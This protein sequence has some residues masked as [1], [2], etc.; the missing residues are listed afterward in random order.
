MTQSER[1]DAECQSELP[2][3]LALVERMTAELRHAAERVVP[4]FLATM[5]ASYFRGTDFE[6]RL[7]HIKAVIAAEASGLSQE[8]ILRHEDG[9]RFTYLGDRNYPGQLAEL[10]ELLP[11]E[12]A[13]R[14]CTVHTSN[15]G[16]LVLDV[17]EL[18]DAPRFDPGDP[19]QSASA[20]EVL[21]HAAREE[22]D[23]DAPALE[24]HFARCAAD[25]LLSAPPQRICRHFRLFESLRGS[26]DCRVEIETLAASPLAQLVVAV[27]N[28]SPQE[29]LR[30][31]SRVFGRHEID[32][33]SA[34]LDRFDTPEGDNV[35]LL[36]FLVRWE[37]EP[38]GDGD[39]FEPLREDLM[40]LKWLDE[41]ALRLWRKLPTADLS[42]AEALQALC[43]LAHQVLTAL[44]PLAF[45]RKHVIECV[46]EHLPL[47]IR[48]AELFERRFDPE[49]PLADTAFTA[50]REEI[51][52]AIEESLDDE[53][54]REVFQTLLRAVLATRASNL[55]RRGRYAL[56]LELDPALLK[57][58]NREELPH[59]VLFV[60]GRDFDGF[61]L[62]FRPIARGGLRLVTPKGREQFFREAERLY[63]EAYGLAFAQQLKNKDIPEGGAKGVVLVAPLG[64]V[65][66]CAKAFASALLDMVIP[67]A[68]TRAGSSSKPA[69]MDRLYLGPDEN[70]TTELITWIVEHAASRGYPV[71]NSFMSSKPGAGINH[72]TYGVTSEGLSVFLEAALKACGIDPRARPFTL[73]LTGGPDGDVGGNTIRI[74][75]RDYAEHARIVGI[76]DGSGCAEDPQGLDHAELLRLV[77]AGL[78]VASF[79]RARLGPEGRVVALHEPNGTKLR[80]TLHNRVV[81]DAFVP[82]GGRP[83]TL[84]EGNWREFL[85][86]TNEPSAKLI[87]EGAN[88]FLTPEARRELS[89][90]GVLIV[91]DSS[92][93]KC[94]VITSSFEI[95]AS[96]LL[97]ED[98]FLSVKE[99]FVG[100]VIVRLRDLAR[101]EAEFLMREA[102][103]RPGIPLPELST[104]LSRVLIAASDAI[105]PCL[106]RI[107]REEPERLW[108]LMEE[109]LPPV[110][111][112]RAVGRLRTQLPRGYACDAIAKSLAGTIVYR[113]GL[114]YLEGMEP[115]AI[116]DL[117]LRYVE[118]ERETRALASRVL[119]SRLPERE[120][121]AA[122]LRSSATRVS[123]LR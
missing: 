79:E 15:D 49:A 66:L 111:R 28:C 24:E 54:E 95:L 13:L 112:E 87:V 75:H 94:G 2:D 17:F 121:I 44:N 47:A 6:T 1:S 70:V 8:L 29:M 58:A 32:I 119:A 41:A 16:R 90:R 120:R 20:R 123:P 57:A 88:L 55:H 9:S 35:C 40:R 39:P 113:E 52:R 108:S 98:E 10:L 4:R 61:H 3:P 51:E 37:K 118:A 45:T 5:P 100:E 73:K 12:R 63:D 48:I 104:R 11:S 91:K 30:R 50:M 78:P 99:R 36:S 83:R 53:S 102:R 31:I 109:Y 117:A 67:G 77:A 69:E 84:H 114:A 18:G 14:S 85:T 80:N 7:A 96:M 107:E 105:G 101:R 43:H 97:S 64:R 86:A 65:D 62:R 22:R 110:L 103:Y 25:Y 74:L 72:K 34:R 82:A 33:R 89:R 19:L 92:A 115:A 122:L 116:A 21:A 27:G 23:L 93:N 76:A 81:A 26:E 60:H 42:R 56:A 46:D 106:A 38:A 68:H 71:P 59:G